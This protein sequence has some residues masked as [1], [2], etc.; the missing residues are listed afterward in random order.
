MG[1]LQCPVRVLLASE[2]QAVEQAERLRAERIAVVVSSSRAELAEQV[3]RQLGV[4]LSVRPTELLSVLDEVADTCRG[5]TVL[6]VSQTDAIL[7]LLESLGLRPV[8]EEHS[9]DVE[10]LALAGDSAGWR[11]VPLF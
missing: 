3:A 7:A 4:T 11:R 9:D 8:G 6:V 2:Q 5:E 10:V 1:D